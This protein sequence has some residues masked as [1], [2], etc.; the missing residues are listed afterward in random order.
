MFNKELIIRLRKEQ[1]LTQ[2]E[3]AKRLGVQNSTVNWIESGKNDNPKF[4]LVCKIAD[5]F[6]VNINQLRKDFKPVK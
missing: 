5:Y 3:L 1:G 4:H 6:E 2:L